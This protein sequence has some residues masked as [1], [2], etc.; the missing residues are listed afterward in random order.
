M[1]GTEPILWMHKRTLL[2]VMTALLRVG[3]GQSMTRPHEPRKEERWSH[4]QERTYR[5]NAH[6]R[7]D[8]EV[9]AGNE[10]LAEAISYQ[11]IEDDHIEQTRE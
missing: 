3:L 9:Y 5:R 4:G 7:S 6:Q 10:V 2:H 8:G 11:E 1:P